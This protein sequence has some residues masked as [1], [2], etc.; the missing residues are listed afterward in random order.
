MFRGQ[1]RVSVPTLNVFIRCDQDILTRHI[2]SVGNFKNKTRKR[3]FGEFASGLRCAL[4]VANARAGGRRGAKAVRQISTTLVI[5]MGTCCGVYAAVT[6]KTPRAG[7]ALLGP[8]GRVR[9]EI[10]RLRHRLLRGDE[11]LAPEWSRSIGR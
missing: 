5:P 9:L 8:A 11:Q 10:A 3:C 2:L 6:R 1:T 4:R 7:T